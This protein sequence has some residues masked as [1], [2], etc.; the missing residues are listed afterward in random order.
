MTI[1]STAV[2]GARTPFRPRL[3]LAGLA[4]GCLALTACGSTDDG[5]DTGAA[6]TADSGS[7]DTGQS[8]YPVSVPDCDQ[9][10]TFD[11]APER[12]LTIGSAAVSLLDAAGATSR[13]VARSG[14]FGAPLPDDLTDPP[15][16]EVIDPSDPSTEAVIGTGADLVYGYGLF[17]ADGDQL[18]D[19]GMP[20]M[21]VLGE[22]GQ[23]TGQESEDVAFSTISDDIR[24]L[25]TVFGT[26]DEAEASA[27]ALD[28]R[29]AD[30]AAQAPTDDP[31]VAWVYFFSLSDGPSAYGGEGMPQAVMDEAGLDNVFG[32]EDAFITLDVESL[33]AADPEWLVLSYGTNGESAEDAREQLLAVEGTE[34][35][36]A[37]QE[38]RIILVP[39]QVSQP[40]T[41]AADGLEQLVE[42]TSA[43]R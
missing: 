37:V 43:G 34:E 6:D 11:A 40:S 24:R 29:V 38:D 39:W 9:E 28:D 36:T 42:A 16:A 32:E 20:V 30:L 1:R 15:E 8:S 18:R 21:T 23:D 13:V 10:L 22:C 4:V 26:E 17:N 35:L 3:A 41:E 33:L 7:S 25:G 2:P 27:T 14:E 19:A 12:V 5:A 31:S